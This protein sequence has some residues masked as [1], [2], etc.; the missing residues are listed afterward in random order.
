M[1]RNFDARPLDAALVDRVVAA[2]LRGPSAGHTQGVDLVVLETPA[3]TG[4]YWDA[5]LPI[6]MFDYLAAGRPIVSTPRLATAALLQRHGAGLI[7]AGEGPADLAEP[8]GR[9]LADEDLS[10][11]LGVAARRA[12]ETTYDWNVIGRRLAEDILRREEPLRWLR[13]R[14]SVIRTRVLR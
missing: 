4:R 13:R 9:L 8:I 12:A 10:R 2:G 3:E 11:R 14:V 1:I 6:K 5:V 7:A